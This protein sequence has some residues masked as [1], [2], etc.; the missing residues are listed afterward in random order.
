MRSPMRALMSRAL[1]GVSRIGGRGVPGFS[2]RTA[3]NPGGRRAGGPSGG[4][5]SVGVEAVLSTGN[6]ACKEDVD[7]D[8]LGFGL[9]YIGQTMFHAE[10]TSNE[11]WQCQQRAFAPLPLVP[12]AQA[13]NY[14]QSIFEGLKATRTAKGRVALFRPYRNAARMRDGARRMLMP[15]VPDDMFIRAVEQ[16]VEANAEYVPPFGK[17]SLYIRPLLFGSGSTLGPACAPSFTF[18]IFCAAVGSY[19]KGGQLTPVELAIEEHFHRAAPGGSGGTKAAANYSPVLLPQRN[20]Q[21]KGFTDVLYL[22]S[23]TDTYLEEGT[24]CNVFIAKGRTL[25]TPPL[26]G[27]ILPGVTRESVLELA[28]ARGYI[29]EETP[30]SVRE[31]LEADELFVVGTAAV[32]SPAGSLTYK[33]RKR[34]YGDGK[35]PTPI[36]MELYEALTSIQTEREE[37]PFG[38]VHPVC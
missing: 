16:V 36:A 27:T 1:P 5:K 17:G 37:D 15:D 32:V 20:A 35:K 10:W 25:K 14:G 3:M 26:G 34:V 7:W 38:W 31:A 9:D 23:K 29:T 4:A 11:G 30:V 28:A 22:D 21:A 8:K 33:G 13:L 6:T 18:V 12:T 2:T 24:A 19:F